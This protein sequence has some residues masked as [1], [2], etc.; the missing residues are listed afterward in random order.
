M[1]EYLGPIG[2]ILNL[3]FFAWV[4]SRPERKEK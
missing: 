4:V 2:V 3:A 1:I